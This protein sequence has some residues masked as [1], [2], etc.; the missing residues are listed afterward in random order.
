MPCRRPRSAAE[1]RSRRCTRPWPR[2]AAA[3]VHVDAAAD[4][5]RVGGH[6]RRARARRRAAERAAGAV[7][8]ILRGARPRAAPPHPL[9]RAAAPALDARALL[10]R[11][12]PR[13]PRAPR[14]RLTERA[15]GGRV[16][17]RG[18]ERRGEEERGGVR[19]GGRVRSTA[20]P[21]GGGVPRARGARRRPRSA[22]A[23]V[24]RARSRPTAVHRRRRD[25]RVEQLAVEESW[26]FRSL[27]FTRLGASRA[28][29]VAP[30]KNIQKFSSEHVGKSK[31][32]LR[33][34]L[35][36]ALLPRVAQ[37]NNTTRIVR[38]GVG[39]A[40]LIRY[41]SHES[42]ETVGARRPPDRSP[43]ASSRS[44]LHPSH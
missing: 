18:E 16:A 33:D 10:R 9:P 30:R 15:P 17:G 1:P 27:L 38:N 21:G 42:R 37:L 44:S 43:H 4:V 32:E 24:D 22:L 29:R 14:H 28:L 23:R 8:T 13:S 41:S 19:H 36:P 39:S 31:F 12:A 3:A 7:S 26:I 25:E 11:A 6:A 35:L 20:G 34:A 40:L 5:R 2:A